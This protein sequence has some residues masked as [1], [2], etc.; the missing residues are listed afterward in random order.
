MASSLLFFFPFSSLGHFLIVVLFLLMVVWSREQTHMQPNEPPLLPDPTSVLS[1]H[2]HSRWD[3]ESD[4]FFVS[5]DSE[6]G[7]GSNLLKLERP[8]RWDHVD[9]R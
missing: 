4:S 1:P 3:E 8:D 7:F 5:C 6:G 2:T 9:D